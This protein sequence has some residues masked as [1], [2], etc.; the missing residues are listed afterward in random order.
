MPFY[1]DMSHSDINNKF[2]RIIDDI[3]QIQAQI[4]RMSKDSPVNQAQFLLD[5]ASVELVDLK[6]DLTPQ[7]EADGFVTP[8]EYLTTS[9][10]SR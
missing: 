7:V 4:Q 9:S 10:P 2:E 6:I 3:T 5:T 8:K 1:A